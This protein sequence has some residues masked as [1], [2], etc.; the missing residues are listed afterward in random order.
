[1]V[2]ACQ[3][4]H[5][6]FFTSCFYG[7]VFVIKSTCHACCW[8]DDCCIE[9][10]SPGMAWYTN[11]AAVSL[12]W[13][14]PIWLPWRHMKNALFFIL[15]NELNLNCGSSGLSSIEFPKMKLE[16]DRQRVFFMGASIYNSLPL[17]L[18]NLNDIF[19]WHR[20][21]LNDRNTCCMLTKR[22][23]FPCQRPRCRTCKFTGRT[24][25]INHART[26]LYTE[27]DATPASK[28]INLFTYFCS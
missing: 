21:A 19:I 20:T 17:E 10:N 9:F 13:N 7:C 22:G 5:S 23:T 8:Y 3:Y 28:N 1:M 4:N 16:F 2:T 6:N 27:K 11:M 12:F 18:G 15:P 26:E 25:N 24:A 14:T